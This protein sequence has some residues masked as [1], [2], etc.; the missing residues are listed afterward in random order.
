VTS[1]G[2]GLSVL[3]WLS[4]CIIL[5]FPSVLYCLSQ[6]DIIMCLLGYLCGSKEWEWKTE[7][8]GKALI[9]HSVLTLNFGELA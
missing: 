8:E 7:E 2:Q 9:V 6:R 4:K 5:T 3:Y 1:C